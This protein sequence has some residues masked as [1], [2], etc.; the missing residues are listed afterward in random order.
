MPFSV[1]VPSNLIWQYTINLTSLFS[2]NPVALVNFSLLLLSVLL[3][4]LSYSRIPF[5]IILKFPSPEYEILFV[6]SVLYQN[7]TVWEGRTKEGE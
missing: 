7:N 4:S 5:I 6:I 3:Y 1:T 2:G